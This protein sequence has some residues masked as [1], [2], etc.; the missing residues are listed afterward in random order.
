MKKVMFILV[1][2]LTMAS[3]LVA[4]T[5][6]L[7]TTSIDNLADGSVVAKEFIFTGVGTDSFRQGIK[8]APTETVQWQFKV[9]NYENHIITETDLYYKLTFN[10]HAT[11][12]KSAIDPLVVTVKDLE[13]RVFNRVTGVGSFD[14]IGS[15]MLSEIGQEKD[16]IVEINWPGD[17]RNDNKYAGGKYGTSI[18]V[19]AVASQLPLSNGTEPENQDISVRYE[20]TFPWQNGQSNIYE[21]A[22]KVTITNNTDTTIK[23]W[24]I[25][26]TLPTDSLSNVWS[27]AKFIHGLPK[28]FYK[29]INPDYNNQLADDILPGQSVSF[30]GPARGTGTE[31]IENIIVD[32]SNVNPSSNVELT[33]EFGKS[34]L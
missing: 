5:L 12:N 32:G 13:G 8:I 2:V 19:D 17:G 1:L 14:V 31:A 3:S 30:S 18:K 9:K 22:Y 23:D 10:V 27:N 6:A 33:C 21:F 16:Y 11:E 25:E 26:F 15:F 34:S 24:A 28:G 7:Y 29:F 20:T 4:G